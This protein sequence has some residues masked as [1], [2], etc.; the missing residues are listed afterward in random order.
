MVLHALDPITNKP[1]PIQ[2]EEISPGEWGIKTTAVLSTGSVTIDVDLDGTGVD[3]D[4]VSITDEDG[5]R[6]NVIDV[7][8]TNA[9]AVSVRGLSPVSS[10]VHLGDSGGVEV[11]VT[12]IS[13]EKGLNTHIIDDVV[14]YDPTDGYGMSILKDFSLPSA[15][16]NGN[17]T[18][19]ATETQLNGGT[20]QVVKRGVTVQADTTNTESVFIG[21]TGVTTSNGME[22]TPGE[23]FP[24][25]IDDIA[26]IY[27]I[28]ASGGQTAR[29]FG[30]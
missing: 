22:L 27:A 12:D 18:I 30:S 4:T 16:F 26:E 6:V 28:S 23:S 25:E 19:A 24:V 10:G 8:G 14:G 11:G 2:V 13:G 1:V 21:V 7:S 9:M 15:A 5:T 17:D 20:P 29:W 3:G